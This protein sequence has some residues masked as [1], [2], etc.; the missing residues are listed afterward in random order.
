MVKPAQFTTCVSVTV[1]DGVRKLKPISKSSQYFC[2]MI[3]LLDPFA[4][5]GR[6]NLTLPPA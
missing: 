6:R 1:M 5:S 4:P 3:H 2:D